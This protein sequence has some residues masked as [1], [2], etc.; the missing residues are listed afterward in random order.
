MN[1][2]S[3]MKV[4]SRCWTNNWSSQTRRQLIHS[5]PSRVKKNLAISLNRS[6]FPW[7]KP[8][9]G[10]WIKAKAVG[11][12]WSYVRGR[13]R[14]GPACAMSLNP[15]RFR[16]ND[17]CDVRVSRFIG[18]NMWEE[19]CVKWNIP[20]WGD[21]AARIISVNPARWDYV[22]GHQGMEVIVTGEMA[23]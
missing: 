19:R 5:L 18:I 15:P 4:R 8:R 12:I 20:G 3:I 7:L 16:Y 1:P 9:N 23:W 6:G 10:V 13:V 2:V 22:R 14:A 17:H 21:K 11:S